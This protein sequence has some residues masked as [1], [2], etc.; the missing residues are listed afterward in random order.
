MPDALVDMSY[1]KAEL[2]DQ[3]KD[4]AVGC[5]GQPNPYPWGLS[6][7]LETEA[8]EKLG[9]KDL[10]KVGIK[11]QFVAVAEITN[12]AQS[13]SREQDDRRSVGLQI[14]KMQLVAAAAGQENT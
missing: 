12:V 8:L 14:T 2:K 5:N 4:M 11:I 10:P 1:T 13:A 7:H 3:K 6:L 9:V